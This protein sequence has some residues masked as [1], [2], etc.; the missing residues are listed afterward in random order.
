[1]R[2]DV[3]QGADVRMRERGNGPAATLLQVKESGTAKRT[4]RV[5]ARP[6]PTKPISRRRRLPADQK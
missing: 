6:G 1:V 4:A 2:P 3:V 5:G